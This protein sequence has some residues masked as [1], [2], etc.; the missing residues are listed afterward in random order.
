MLLVL[1]DPGVTPGPLWA[2]ELNTALGLVDSHDHTTNSGVKV[3]VAG[4]NMNADLTMNDHALTDVDLL[5]FTDLVTVPVTLG[6]LSMVDGDLYFTD[7]S[8]NQVP[9]VVNGTISGAT[10]NISG[11]SPP[12]SASYSN[13][14]NAFSFLK[15]TNKPGRL[16]I[17]E[18]SIYE[19]D[20]ATAD[21]VT[22]KS[23]ASLA[24]AYTLILPVGLP[25]TPQLLVLSPSGELTVSPELSNPIGAVPIGGIIA[26]TGSTPGAYVCTE[27]TQ[28][29]ASGYCLC[30]GQVLVDGRS[31]MNGQTMPLLTSNAFLQGNTVS[32]ST[33]G[34]IISLA[35][36]HDMAS[37]THEMAHYHQWMAGVDAGGGSGSLQ[38][39]FSGSTAQ[40]EFVPGFGT[41]FIS[42]TTIQ[43]GSGG[44]GATFS[45]AGSGAGKWYTTGVLGNFTGSGAGANTN[46][47]STNTTSSALAGDNRPPYMDVIYVIRVF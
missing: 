33:G 6:A 16:N 7:T 44:T 11:M 40:G 35:H 13:I 5:Q 42:N 38:G 29:D 46:V 22:I 36:T 31:P 45:G 25:T 4:L 27:N 9:I 15:D 3:P 24:N 34:Q 37:H 2:Q 30:Q 32:G 23:P 47:P 41:V 1:P 28:G 43:G 19:F 39:L 20:N 26:T 17:S 10:G 18:I 21:P 12:A 14:T 8:G